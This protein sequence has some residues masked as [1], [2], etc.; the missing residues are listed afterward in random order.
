MEEEEEE[1][2]GR[3]GGYLRHCT[4]AEDALQDGQAAAHDDVVADVLHDARR[5]PRHQGQQDGSWGRG[6]R[7]AYCIGGTSRRTRDVD[8][9]Y[10]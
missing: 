5:L 10:K 9:V 1:E 7:A 6:R 4:A 3:G 2:D 8:H